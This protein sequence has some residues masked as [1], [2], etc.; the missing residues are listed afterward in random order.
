MGSSLLIRKGAI[1]SNYIGSDKQKQNSRRTIETARLE[2]VRIAKEKR[3][4]NEREYFKSPKL[5]LCCGLIIPF[6]QRHKKFCNSSCF[7]KYS[8]KNRGSHS[9]ETKS[10][11]RNGVNAYFESVG[12]RRY[13]S[14]TQRVK[15]DV[16]KKDVVKKD[17]VPTMYEWTCPYCGKMI[18]VKKY[19]LN[20]RKI[21]GGEDCTRIHLSIVGK[22]QIASGKRTNTWGGRCKK[23]NYKGMKL[24]GS[25]ELEFVKWC[26]RRGLSVKRN[27][28]GFKYVRADGTE[29][30]YFPDF[31]IDNNLFIECKGYETDIDQAKWSQF[32]F[33]LIILRKKE[34][35]MLKCDLIYSIDQ[36]KQFLYSSS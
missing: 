10:K 18:L 3:I 24:D 2:S 28:I 7:A 36:L 23:I 11:I 6:K 25:F 22:E 21:C 32:P 16:V 27:R 33:G 20:K 5:C 12:R 14:D 29:H 31:E 30:S 9:Q 1:M 34:I 19:Y 35:K 4:Q 17:V 26:E 8:N 15:K 13:K